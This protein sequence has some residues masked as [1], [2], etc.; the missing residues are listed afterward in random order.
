MVQVRIHDGWCWPRY[1]EQV[2][3]T[4]IC[5]AIEVFRPQD[6]I[7]DIARFGHTRLSHKMGLAAYGDTGQPCL[8]RVVCG[9]GYPDG[10]VSEA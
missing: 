5:N 3:V 10:S 8:R 4:G 1:V 6:G 7:N 2:V 9:S